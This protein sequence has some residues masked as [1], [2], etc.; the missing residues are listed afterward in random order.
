MQSYIFSIITPV[1]SH[2]SEIILM[3][4]FGKFQE[5][6]LIIIIKVRLKT[7]VLLN[8]YVTLSKE[9]HLLEYFVRL[10][11]S[12][13]SLLKKNIQTQNFWTIVSFF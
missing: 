4:W 13:L 9:Q 1:F 3:W 10:K 11:M 7:I 2:P 6:F 8:I 5:Y 12:L